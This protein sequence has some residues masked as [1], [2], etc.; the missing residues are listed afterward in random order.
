M[1]VLVVGLPG[2]IAVSWLNDVALAAT[3]VSVLG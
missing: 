2:G 1:F 3:W